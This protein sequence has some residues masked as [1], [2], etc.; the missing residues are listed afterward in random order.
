MRLGV[1]SL[2]AMSAVFGV[3]A[4]SST[5]ATTPVDDVIAQIDRMNA[6][7]LDYDD[8]PAE[9]FERMSQVLRAAPTTVRNARAK[10][11]IM[12]TLSM[13]VSREAAGKRWTIPRPA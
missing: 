6:D 11:D 1:K 2:L 3:A 10:A 7:D 9:D 5:P 12:A 4:C 8:V 13:V